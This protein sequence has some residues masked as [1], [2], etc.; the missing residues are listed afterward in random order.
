[1]LSKITIGIVFLLISVCFLSLSLSA[2]P[3]IDEAFFKDVRS[4]I[5]L[6]SIG[7]GT[8]TMKISAL[9]RERYS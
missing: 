1:M 4:G 6:L 3:T 9:A 7:V 8:V 2:S 5:L